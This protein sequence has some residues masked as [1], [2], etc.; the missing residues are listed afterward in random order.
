MER[1]LDGHVE[2]VG[3]GIALV[4]HGERFG[5]VAATAA[6]FA[7]YVHIRQKIHFDAAEAIALAGF[8]APAFYVKAE[9]A[10]AIAALARFGKHGEK[11]ANRREDAGVR[12][13]I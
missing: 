1:F 13:G 10:G 9:A 12:R 2:N 8:A 6:D 3:D 11:L 4:A 7:G 5:I